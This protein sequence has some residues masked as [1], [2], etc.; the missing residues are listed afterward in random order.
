MWT[1]RI[2][3]RRE[4]TGKEGWYEIRG[5]LIYVGMNEGTTSSPLLC[6]FLSSPVVSSPL[7]SFPPLLCLFPLLITCPLLVSSPLS[8]PAFASPLLPSLVC[9]LIPFPFLFSPL[10]AFPSYPLLSPNF[11]SLPL[12]HLP[13][14]LPYH[15]FL[16]PVVSSPVLLLSFSLLHLSPILSIYLSIFVFSFLSCCFLSSLSL[17]SFLLL[18]FLLCASPIFSVTFP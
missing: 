11:L 4:K 1:C 10:P 18:L 6:H 9:V 17:S 14:L 13:P 3:R 12:F 15:C 2:H 7:L 8:S 16:L 5:K